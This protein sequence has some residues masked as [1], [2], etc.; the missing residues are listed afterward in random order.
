VLALHERCPL[1]PMAD[2][3]SLLLPDGVPMGIAGECRLGRYGGIRFG[4]QASQFRLRTQ[5]VFYQEGLRE[6]AVIVI[7]VAA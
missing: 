5:R 2:F 3:A 4:P 7:V 1:I 6:C